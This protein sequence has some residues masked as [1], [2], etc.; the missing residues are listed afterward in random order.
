LIVSNKIKIK[1]KNKQI[2]ATSMSNSDGTERLIEQ[3]V[4]YAMAERARVL[5]GRTNTLATEPPIDGTEDMMEVTVTRTQITD[6]NDV[7]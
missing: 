7:N 6:V 1:Q 2:A 5:T 3:C 4:Y